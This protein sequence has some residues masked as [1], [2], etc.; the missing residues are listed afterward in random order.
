MLH[1]AR[2]LVVA[3]FVARLVEELEAKRENDVPQLVKRELHG[4]IVPLVPATVR[5]VVQQ[6]PVVD[7]VVVVVVVVAAAAAAVV[8]VVVAA[9]VVVAVVVVV[10]M[11]TVGTSESVHAH[12]PCDANAA[13]V[14]CWGVCAGGVLGGGAGW[15]GTPWGRQGRAGGLAVGRPVDTRSSCFK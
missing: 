1:A 15:Q 7:L 6:R 11:M 4:L 12:A 10:A 13:G 2:V 8:V 14:L 9:V 3:A 5:P